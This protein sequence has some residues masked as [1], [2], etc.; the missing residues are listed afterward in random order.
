MVATCLLLHPCRDKAR[1]SCIV[2]LHTLS[3]MGRVGAAKRGALLSATSRVIDYTGLCCQGFLTIRTCR[4]AH[5]LT[6]GRLTPPYA[7]RYNA[8][9]HAVT[10]VKEKEAKQG[11]G[12]KEMEKGREKA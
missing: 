6:I 11:E 4:R 2:C 12:A 8:S 7:S 5:N 3:P 1:R 10:G 9:L